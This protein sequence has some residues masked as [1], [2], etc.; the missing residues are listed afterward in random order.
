MWRQRLGIVIP[1]KFLRKE[2]K[3]LCHLIKKSRFLLR[4]AEEYQKRIDEAQ[5]SFFYE[6]DVMQK[7]Y[8]LADPEQKTRFFNEMA[9]R[10]LYSLYS[11]KT[12]PATP[13]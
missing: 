2:K 13:W 7:D 11:S 12:I 3:P 6:I 1:F 8:D 5:N 9:K 10:L 4:V